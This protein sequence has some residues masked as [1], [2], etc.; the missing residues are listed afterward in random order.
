MLPIQTQVMNDALRK[1]AKRLHYPIEIMLICARWYAAY[2]LSLRHIQEMMAERGVEVDHATIHRW[3]MKIL[4]ALAKMFRHRKRPVG[5]SWRVDETY[6]KVHSEWKY[7]HRAVDKLGWTA[8]FLPTARRD[9]CA[10]W[11]FF[12]RAM[13]RNDVP[14]KITIDK[15]GANTAAVQG[16]IEDSGLLIE[17]GNRSTSTTSSSIKA[18]RLALS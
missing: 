15:S 9:V 2:P 8:D 12:E 13:D 11:R 4:P 6:V 10:A 1:V 14:E 18:T 16:L 7:L 17:L 5:P 3:A